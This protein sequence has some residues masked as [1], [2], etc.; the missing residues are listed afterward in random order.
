M[1]VDFKATLTRRQNTPA[2]P[3][4]QDHAM[5]RDFDQWLSTFR[6]SIA[7]YNYFVD[8]PKVYRNVEDIRVELNILTSLVGS[9]NI[10]ADF[11]AITTRYPETLACIPILLAVREREIF[12]QAG[13]VGKTFSFRRK[14]LSSADYAEF[15]RETGLFGLL[16]NH[17][18][19]NLVDYVTGVETGLDSNGRKNR[20]GHEM[21]NLVESFLR[22]AGLVAGES[23]WKEVY[24]SQVERD[25][26]LDLSAISN[27]G[28]T[29]KRFDFVI[30]RSLMVYLVETN[31]YRSS[32]SK[33]NE[34]ARSY[35]QL[36]E[37]CRSVSGAQFV[38][39]TD[40][41]GWY[42]ARNNLRETFDAM[43]HIYNIKD[44]ENGVVSTT[45]V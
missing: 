27:E 25:F 3:D 17:I 36:A 5:R 14:N 15:M 2:S 19:A 42:A 26:N 37:E 38:W 24:L 44:L 11:E 45:L 39:I 1:A 12:V 21:E 9:Q 40:G 8:F 16:E 31:F 4:S 32:G 18:I 13:A 43:E 33:L 41:V 10:E 7:G 23:Y 22:G 30:R 34:T 20:G 29:E 35:K 28:T 6:E